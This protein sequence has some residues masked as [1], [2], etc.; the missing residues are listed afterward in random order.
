MPHSATSIPIR[1]RPSRR[2]GASVLDLRV[3]TVRPSFLD[4]RFSG[5]AW[6]LDHGEELLDL[7]LG[8]S[9]LAGIRGLPLDLPSLNQLL[10]RARHA[11]PR[12]CLG[13][14]K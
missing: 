13:R 6:V 8:G 7:C 11:R 12:W 10:D 5:D 4:L 14:R 3:R 1:V 2:T 9:R